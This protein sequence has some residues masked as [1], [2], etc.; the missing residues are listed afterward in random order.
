VWWVA[1][2]PGVS[3][4]LRA[5]EVEQGLEQ[6]QSPRDSTVVEQVVQLELVVRHVQDHVVLA[7]VCCRRGRLGAS[8]HQVSFICGSGR[9]FAKYW[10]WW[11]WD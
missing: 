6:D 1:G 2:V 7:T 10:W 8:V 9:H 4:T 3:A 11:W 5:R